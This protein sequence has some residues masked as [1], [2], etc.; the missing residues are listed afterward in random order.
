[1]TVRGHVPIPNLIAEIANSHGGSADYLRRLTSDL[2]A[3]QVPAVK[4]QY[5]V[6]SDFL[7]PAHPQYQLFKSLEFG[8]E[9]FGGAVKRVHAA[10][11]TAFFDV[12]GETSLALARRAG[13][14][15]FKIYASD[16]GNRPFIKKVVSLGKPVL[17]STGGAALEEIDD[18]VKMCRGRNYCLMVGFQ[19]FPT[20]VEESNVL[21]IRFLRERYGC[22]VGYMDHSPAKDPFSE[23]VPCLAVAQGACCIEKHTFLRDRKTLYDWQS[24]FDPSRLDRLAGLLVKAQSAMGQASFHISHAEKA[25]A[26]AKRKV[27]LAAHPIEKGVRIGYQDVIGRCARIAPRREFFTLNQMDRVVGKVAYRKLAA[28]EVVSPGSLRD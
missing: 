20:P 2:C 16:I 5:I 6:A 1:M 9:I 27:I 22:Q 8:P 21:K 4:F 25:Y 26:R 13:A 28:F 15:G 3:T 7:T 17:I 18:I 23:I 14:D 24:A 10:K 19:S 12:F 11:K